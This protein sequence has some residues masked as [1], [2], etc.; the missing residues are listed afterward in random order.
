MEDFK[1]IEELLNMKRRALEKFD[2]H[3]VHSMMTTRETDNNACKIIREEIEYL[4]DQ[5]NCSTKDISLDE[6]F[7]SYRLSDVVNKDPEH[8]LN[9]MEFKDIEKYLRKRKLDNIKKTV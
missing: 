4:T 2:D 7:L 1:H 6:A 8:Y 3:M 5:I 9:V